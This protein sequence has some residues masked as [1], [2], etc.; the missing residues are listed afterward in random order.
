MFGLFPASKK[1][2]TGEF[3]WGDWGVSDLAPK[4]LQSRAQGFN[5]GSLTPCATRS[6][7][8]E[9]KNMTQTQI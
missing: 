9:E 3:G 8:A 6:E 1:L 5:P 2:W 4:G 7:R